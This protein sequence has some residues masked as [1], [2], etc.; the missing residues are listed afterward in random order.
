VQSLRLT[1]LGGFDLCGP[2]GKKIAIA[3]IKPTLLL[4]YLA[5]RP[6]DTHTRDK[7]MALLWSARGEKQARG[8]LRQ[9]IWALRRAFH[10]MEPDPLVVEGDAL[11]LSPH[12]IEIDVSSLEQLL[13]EGS[14]AAL[15]SAVSLYR[16]PL[17][18]GIR[19]SDPAFQAFLRD[20]QERVLDLVVVAHTHLLEGPPSKEPDETT[21]T[22]AKSL[23]ELDPLQELAHQTLIRHYACKGQIGL[24]VRQYQACCK[25]LREE[26]DAEPS[27]ET[28]SLIENVR[29]CRPCAAGGVD[30]LEESVSKREDMG[31]PLPPAQEK[32]SIAVL[33]FLN[34]SGDP[35]QDY[36]SDGITEDIITGH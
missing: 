15:Q 30:F 6:G 5:L 31:E 13:T 7:L 9:A 2:G 22:T 4:A 12:S 18:E 32:P 35:T 29:L 26:I 8:S 1:L 3:G 11:S 20:E 10:G 24:A 28:E 14:T 33:P 19:V 17:L 16:G 25:V 21:A 23:L 27:A 36:F 34:L